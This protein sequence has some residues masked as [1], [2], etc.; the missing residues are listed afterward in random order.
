MAWTAHHGAH[1]A[2]GRCQS[3]ASPEARAGTTEMWRPILRCTC[4]QSMQTK[5]PC[6]STA[7]PGFSAVQSKHSELHGCARMRL[8]SA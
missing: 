2:R 3:P 5:T 8:S 1:G 7:H 6:G 4:A